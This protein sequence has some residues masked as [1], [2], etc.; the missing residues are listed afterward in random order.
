VV[1][2]VGLDHFRHGARHT[3]NR[4]IGKV[5]RGCRSWSRNAVVRLGD[6]VAVAVDDLS[7]SASSEVQSRIAG[8]VKTLRSMLSDIVGRVTGECNRRL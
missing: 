3:S 8:T 2:S 4:L 5:G 7:K 1:R 6:A